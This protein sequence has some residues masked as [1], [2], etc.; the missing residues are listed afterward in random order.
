VND[1]AAFDIQEVMRTI[2]SAD[3]LLVRF[4]TISPRLFADFRPDE[5]DGPMIVLA[6][7]TAFLT[8]E[9]FHDLIRPY[10]RRLPLPEQLKGIRWPTTVHNLR[11]YGV[12]DALTQRIDNSAPAEEMGRI[13][14]EL[15]R[16]E[17]T[18]LR[19]ILTGD[20]YKTVWEP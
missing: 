15:C 5:P 1:D 2:A 20:D 9:S 12:W 13:F 19:N 18:A 10:R 4:R 17:R 16:L 6:P 7:R 8:V 3:V 14:E 11:S